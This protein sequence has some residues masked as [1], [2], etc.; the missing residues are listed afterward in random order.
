MTI[1]LRATKGS[2]LTHGEMDDNLVTLRDVASQT[3]GSINNV[4]IGASTAAAG[5]FTSLTAAAGTFSGNVIL[6]DAASDT[7]RVNGPLGVRATPQTYYGIALGNASEI[8]GDASPRGISSSAIYSSDSTGLVSAVFGQVRSA[9]ASFT[10]ANAVGIRAGDAVEGAGSTITNQHGFYVDDQTQGTNNYGITSAVSSGTNKWNIYASGTAANYFAGNVGIGATPSAWSS[11]YKVMQI[12]AQGVYASGSNITHVAT[13]YYRSA[14]LAD[15]YISSDFASKYTQEGL[16]HKWYSA[17]SGTAGNTITFTQVLAVEKD[18]SVALQGAT[19]QTG[20][21]ITFPATQSASSDA[22]TLDDYEE[23]TFTPSIA[24]GGASVGV[25]YSDQNGDYTKIGNCVFFRLYIALSAKGSSTG[26]ATISGLPF[27]SSATASTFSAMS[28][29]AN[30]LSGTINS[31]VGSVA[32]SE[33]KVDLHSFSAGAVAG[34]TESSFGN[35]SSVMV[36][37][38]YKI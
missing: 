37:G 34:L 7:V 3:S 11:G 27:T 22:N 16:T 4:I 12:G 13:N 23:G 19:S 36:S 32:Q 38:H 1:T 8:T 18:K 5:N 2:P 35:T 33:T 30:S 10:M 15:T 20:A 6:G 14:A 25:T 28:I 9:A 21:G 26:F 31:V 24:F 29:R 17:P